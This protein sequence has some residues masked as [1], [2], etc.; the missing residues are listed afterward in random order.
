[1]THGTCVFTLTDVKKCFSLRWKE[2]Q[3]WETKINWQG[4][5]VLKTSSSHHAPLESHNATF[6]KDESQE[7]QKG[8]RMGGKG[9]LRFRRKEAVSGQTFA[10]RKIL[11]PIG[12]QLP[13]LTEG[14]NLLREKQPLPCPHK[15][16]GSLLGVETRRF[17]VYLGMT[18]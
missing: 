13:P 6:R 15:H 16:L 17:Q 14:V 5:T 12:S 18:P 9:L 2:S 7:A 1:M 8:R 10:L 3:L 11:K 4:K